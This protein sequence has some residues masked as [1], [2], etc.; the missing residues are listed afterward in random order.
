MG[1]VKTP[2][3]L[4]LNEWLN[5]NNIDVKINRKCQHKHKANSIQ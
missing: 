1:A 2:S 5:T 4:T 3:Y